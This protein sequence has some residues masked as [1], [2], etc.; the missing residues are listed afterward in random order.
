MGNLF[1]GKNSFVNKIVSQ[2]GGGSSKG[3]PK[4]QVQHQSNPIIPMVSTNTRPQGG[5]TAVA[6]SK[7]A[8]TGSTGDQAVF[9]RD[10]APVQALFQ[11]RLEDPGR[12]IQK[13]TADQE[14]Q[15]IKGLDAAQRGG[16]ISGAKSLEAKAQLNRQ[17]ASQVASQADTAEREAGADLGKVVLGRASAAAAFIAAKNSAQKSK[18]RE[19][20]LGIF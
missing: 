9:D 18:K 19:K 7:P 17:Y 15:A 8:P 14:N 1:G 11:R 13:E 10:I 20:F 6:G 4:G 12:I 3:K 16:N 5:R 2:V